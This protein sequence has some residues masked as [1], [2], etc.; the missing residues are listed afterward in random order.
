MTPEKKFDLRVHL[1]DPKTG[2]VEK[3]QPYQLKISGGVQRF[4][5]GGIEFYA[6]GDPVNP[7]LAK[8]LPEPM[9]IAESREAELRKKIKDELKAELK[10]DAEEEAKL[11]KDEAEVKAKAEAE[12]KEKQRIK[13]ELQKKKDDEAEKQRIKDEE[14]KR[15][16]D[17]N[18]GNKGNRNNNKNSQMP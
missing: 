18:R 9:T 17:T 3:I 7:E 10:A 12:E 6:S 4:F 14:A 8:N 5:R 2:K 1:H 15:L 11:K 13:D 16:A